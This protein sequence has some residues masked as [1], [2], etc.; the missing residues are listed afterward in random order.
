M[1]K[2][3]IFE[4]KGIFLTRITPYSTETGNMSGEPYVTFHV[5]F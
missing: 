3:Q 2:E 5:R 4:K 1:K